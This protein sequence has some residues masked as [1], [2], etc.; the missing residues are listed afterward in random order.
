MKILFVHRAFPGQFKELIQP[1]V[2]RGDHLVALGEENAR[3]SEFSSK[4]NLFIAYKLTK[5]NTPNI[6]EGL[7]DIESKILRARAAAEAIEPY[8]KQGY[9]P[10]LIVTHSGWGES[11]FLA[12]IFP[13]TPQLHFLEYFY[14]SEGGDMFFEDFLLNE[15]KKEKAVWQTKALAQVKSLALLSGFESM[16][17][18]ISP[19]KF[20]RSQF[21]MRIQKKCS[22]IHDGIDTNFALPDSSSKF[23]LPSGLTLGLSDPVITFVNRTFEPYRGIHV[24]LKSL[25]T[26]QSK[27]S[28]VQV[29]LVGE[30]TPHVSYGKHRS[31]GR[32]WLTYLREKYSNQ[33]DWSRI[34]SVGRI[35][36]NDLIRLFQISSGHVYL[37]YPFVLS[38]SMLEAMSCG[39]IVV[40]SRT[41]PVLEV[42]Q[43]GF[44]GFL[45][46]FS[47]S[48]QI[49]KKLLYVLENQK[50]CMSIRK[51]ARET[52]L[53]K[54]SIDSCIKARIQLIDKII[55][56]N[57]SKSQIDL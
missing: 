40:G 22:V 17:W 15:Q 27:H 53:K 42:I 49:G 36:H 5:G 4:L 51:A 8:F 23:L 13:K 2:A 55:A 30:D 52:V 39:C 46:D 25:V 6:P 16:T 26:L 9:Y 34:H 45:V 38:W 47:D 11:L 48:E 33:L 41:E 1:L 44:N 43:N 21:P 28:S 10:D 29:V 20:Q 32:G 31:D 3:F 14:G 18:G 7:L 54:Y 12:H 19:T 50:S 37:T 56:L 24:F 57:S 35:K